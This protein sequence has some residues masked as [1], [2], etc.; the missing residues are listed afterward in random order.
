MLGGGEEVLDSW[1]TTAQVMRE[2]ARKVL[3]VTSG[4]K[5]EGKETCWW[6]KEVQESIRRKRMAIR[7]R[8]VKVQG[9]K[10]SR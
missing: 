2:A 3:R 8:E 6:N 4:R 10:E 5:K 7:S 1:E 9:Y